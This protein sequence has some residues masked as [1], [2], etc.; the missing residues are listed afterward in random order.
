MCCSPCLTSSDYR[1][2]FMKLFTSV[3]RSQHAEAPTSVLLSALAFPY[4][5]KGGVI[6]GKASSTGPT[7][8]TAGLCASP[9]EGGEAQSWYCEC[10][11]QGLV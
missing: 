4:G 10:I 5:E 8:E 3:F 7:V 11:R 6:P 9:L 1:I 2:L